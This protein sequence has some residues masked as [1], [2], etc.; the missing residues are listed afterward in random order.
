M[1]MLNA[2]WKNGFWKSEIKTFSVSVFPYGSFD[3]SIYFLLVS[4]WILL[5]ASTIYIYIMCLLFRIQFKFNGIALE[6]RSKS[7][8]RNPFNSESQIIFGCNMFRFPFK[9]FFWRRAMLNYYINIIFE[10]FEPMT[11]EHL[12]SVYNKSRYFV[13]SEHKWIIVLTC[14]NTWNTCIRLDKALI[15]YATCLL[16]A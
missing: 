2:R 9:W 16:A 14:L 7:K 5:V 1:V 4:K 13:T 6:P 10:T 8:R 3:Y 11:I 15:N 12:T